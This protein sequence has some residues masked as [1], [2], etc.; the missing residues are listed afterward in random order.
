VVVGA[1]LPLY[2]WAITG[3]PWF[4]A[5]RLVW[6]YD[7]PGF[8]PDIGPYG[9]GLYEAIFINTRLKLTML[10]TGLFGWPGWS[11]LIFLPLP[12]LARRA[13]RWDWLLLGTLLGL[14]GVH[15][16]YWAFGGADGGFPRYYYAALPALL[17]LTARGIQVSIDLLSRLPRIKG[18]A[19]N[20]GWLP[21]GVVIIFVIYSFFWRLPPLLAAQK[22]K[23]EIT[24]APL[25]AVDRAD[26]PEPALILVQNVDSWRD[27]AAP[28]AANS[29]T[30]DGPLVY[31]IDWGDPYTP[32]LRT[33]FKDRSCWE[34]HQQKLKPCS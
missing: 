20:L 9:Y 8:G 27:F 7:R 25:Q 29:P 18:K 24:P 34:L 28:F 33:Q 19:I 2:W 10:A 23:Y 32:R 30:L 12:F 21:V 5:Y 15:L 22:G 14:V 31:A 26:P 6:P 4:N 17:L 1:L 3:D 16:F 13:N 11:N